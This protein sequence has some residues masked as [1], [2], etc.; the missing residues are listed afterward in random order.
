MEE[1]RIYDH[2]PPEAL[3]IRLTVFV[4]EQGFSDEVDELDT[5]ATHLL[6]L[7]EGKGVATC[8]IYPAEGN[9]FMM[10]RLA[11]LAPFRGMGLGSAL[12]RCAEKAA[13]GAGAKVLKLH[14]Q[15]HARG[16][17]EFCG[18]EAYGEIEDEQGSPHIWMKKKL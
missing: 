10:G 4:D 2:L 18:Y 1:I 9:I 12:L 14:A 3:A 17:Y 16:F 11:V 7:R 15:L 5:Y 13:R 8:R 6:L